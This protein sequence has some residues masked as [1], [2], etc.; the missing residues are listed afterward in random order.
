MLSQVQP[1]KAGL[2]PSP[3]PGAE[4]LKNI[5]EWVVGDLNI[6]TDLGIDVLVLS[7]F[8]KTLKEEAQV[9]QGDIHDIIKK[10]AKM[11]EIALTDQSFHLLYE[12]G[13]ITKRQKLIVI[14]LKYAVSVRT[15]MEHKRW[16]RTENGRMRLERESVYVAFEVPKKGGKPKR[17]DLAL[18][19]NNPEAWVE[20]IEHAISKFRPPTPRVERVLGAIGAQKGLARRYE[21]CFT[22]KRVIVAKIMVSLKWLLLTFIISVP[23]GLF[24][25]AALLTTI[26]EGPFAEAPIFL[27]ITLFLFLVPPTM[28]RYANKQR[29]K[30]LRKSPPK[31]I[32][33]DDKKNF[34]IPYRKITLLEIKKGIWGF[35]LHKIKILANSEKHE[36]GIINKKQLSNQVRLVRSVLPEKKLVLPA[37]K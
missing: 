30:R 17:F 7:D 23:A 13:F 31:S 11:K 14:P 1:V 16:V 34:E 21:L 18:I 8:L 9:E 32:L 2:Y 35:T 29:I 4:A 15:E 24:F 6:L 28:G 3:E 19:V 37:R 36:F 25:L 5:A 20:T 27:M 26:V 12:K 22:Q 33:A 10:T